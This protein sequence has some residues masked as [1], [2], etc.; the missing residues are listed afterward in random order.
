MR[1][2]LVGGT[3]LIGSAI[4][5]RLSAEG[6][7]CVLVSRH[8][9]VAADT[10][11]ITLDVAR[12]TDASKWKGILAG[13]DA[14]I[15]AAGALQGQD[16][17]GVHVTGSAAL[18][19]A[20]ESAGVRRVILFSA[21]GSNRDARTDFSRSKRDGEAAL[22][23]RDLDWVVLRPSVVVGRPAYGGSALLR[24][25][26]SLPVLPAMPDTAA[27]QPVHLDDVVDTVV[28]FLQPG[29]PSRV[30]L[31]LAGPQRMAFS[32]AVAL[33]RS[34]LR[35]RP[36]YRLHLPSWAASAFYR[37][38]DLAQM[39]GWATPVNS[40]ARVEM[41]RG[42]TGDP[43]PW[44]QVT[45]LGPRDV[46]LALAREPASVQERWFARLYA[47]KPL[48]FGVF[49]LFWIGTG[50]ISLGPGWETGMSLLREGRLPEDVAA[51]TVTGGALADIVIGLAIL[52]RPLSRY[53]L[54]AALII[55]LTYAVIGTTLVPRLWSDPLGPMLK[56]WPVIM[57][58]LVA[59]A[60]R[61]DR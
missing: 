43:Q 60:I 5:A 23:E 46:E 30:A 56:I 49:G 39:L 38:G 33:F 25:L 4:Q 19:A 18:Y 53:G 26:A 28:F 6:H 55:S 44:R 37:A 35:W 31:D 15:N 8:P 20:C 3:G 10:H 12:T 61:E 50:I 13:A 48:I 34:W 42:A 1:I 9:A 47:L 58:N 59:M 45:G 2:L 41:Q 21:I 22:M 16:M 36:A 57:L 32:D 24:G 52:W 40:T 17:Q 51:V 29:A 14:V 54:W 11:H 27:I 7:E